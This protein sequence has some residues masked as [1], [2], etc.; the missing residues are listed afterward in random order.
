M[1]MVVTALYA[2][3]T[4]F[5]LA[6][7]IAFSGYLRPAT[8][9]Y[10]PPTPVLGPRKTLA[11]DSPWTTWSAPWIAALPRRP[12]RTQKPGPDKIADAGTQI[13]QPNVTRRKLEP[14]NPS[15]CSFPRRWPTGQTIANSLRVFLALPTLTPTLPHVGLCRPPSNTAREVPNNTLLSL[16]CPRRFAHPVDR[17]LTLMCSC[18]RGVE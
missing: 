9:A 5:A 18:A 14:C 4:P 3:L 2:N 12:D 17:T 10:R 11:F 13:G 8:N 6:I 1:A 15:P 16:T 7:V